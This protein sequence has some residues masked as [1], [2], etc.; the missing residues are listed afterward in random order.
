MQL[1]TPVKKI[2]KRT[3][4]SLKSVNNQRTNLHNR[5]GC[6]HSISKDIK[7]IYYSLCPI[8]EELDKD[9]QAIDVMDL[10]YY[11]RWLNE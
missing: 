7:D 8:Y 3:F 5:Y 2:I 6:L 11:E 10:I 9:F 1:E 4:I